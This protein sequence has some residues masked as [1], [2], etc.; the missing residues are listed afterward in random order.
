MRTQNSVFNGENCLLKFINFT[1]VVI[2]FQTIIA[3][4]HSILVTDRIEFAKSN[5]NIPLGG[6]NFISCFLIMLLPYIYYAKEMKSRKFILGLLSL[7]IIFTRSLSGLFVL[8]FLIILW[9]IKS[10]KFIIRIFQMLLVII[11]FVLGIKKYLHYFLNVIL[12]E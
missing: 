6:S 1:T 5:I 2:S 11:I 4:I 12:F 8:L 7:S 3:S 9:S 10:D